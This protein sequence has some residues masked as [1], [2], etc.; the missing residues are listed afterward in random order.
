MLTYRKGDVKRWHIAAFILLSAIVHFVIVII[1]SDTPSITPPKD[2]KVASIEISLRN[3]LGFDAKTSIKPNMKA[4]SKD[5]DSP[6]ELR[7][8]NK[9]IYNFPLLNIPF[10][11]AY[12]HRAHELDE[13][14]HPIQN[15]ETEYPLEAKENGVTGMVKLELFIDETGKIVNID[16]LESIPPRVFENT[17]IKSF[18]NKLFFA[19]KIKERSV[20]SRIITT[21]RFEETPPTANP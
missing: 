19:G 14:P 8:S 10:N 15:I 16:I 2:H 9:K 18:A 20:K 12:Y 3:T 4:A 6:L 1:L 13:L 17:A 21:I 5:L 7:D 11:D